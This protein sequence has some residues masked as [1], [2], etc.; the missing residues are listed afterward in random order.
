MT[1]KVHLGKNQFVD[2]RAVFW[3]ALVAAV[4]FFLTTSFIVP[5]IVGGNVWVIVRL[6]SSIL[7]GPDRLAP[8]A[9]F[10]GTALIA[11]MSIHLL[12]SFVFTSILAII[13]HR[14]GLVTGI[15]LG[16]L[17]GWSLYLINIYS[18]T[19]FFPWFAVMKHPAFLAAHVLFGMTSGGVYE[20]LE[21]EPAGPIKNKK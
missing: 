13:T 5:L 9:T 6:L 1:K 18:L 21:V 17:F 10:D 11:G 7:L 12:L 14:W 3:A 4:V 19:I 8:P 15:L 20:L 16:G 2:W